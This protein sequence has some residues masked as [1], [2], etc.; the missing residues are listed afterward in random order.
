MLVVALVVQLVLGAGLIVVAVNGFP[1]IG[2]GGDA[3]S[4][5]RARGRAG[6]AA[7]ERRPL[8]RPAR[9]RPH[10]PPAELRPAPG[11][12]GGSCAAWPRCCATR[13]PT[14]A[15]SRSRATPA[16]ATSSGRS[17]AGRRPSS[18]ARTTTAS[19]TPRASSAPTTA[20]PGTAAVVELAR[21]L[22]H[23]G[24]LRPRGALRALRRRGGGPRLLER[25]LRDVRAA[26]LARLRRRA[27]RARSGRWCCSTTS[28]TRACAC[29]ARAARPRRCGRACARRRN[30]V[31]V[32]AV[33]PP[34]DQVTIYD[35][36]TPVPARRHPRGRPHRLLLPLRRRPEGHASTSSRSRASTRWGR[37]CSRS[38]SELRAG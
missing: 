23:A 15:S 4:D 24:R 35:D 34:T 32:G 17:P 28:P 10:P 20:P 18:S 38:S 30:E 13:C 16:C 3:K 25:A 9:V 11:R 33:F 8:R 6:G 12:L 2:G 21:D 36:H 26:R 19:T 22:Q 27:P 37:R 29:R 5:A 1:L 14:G 7:A 31:G